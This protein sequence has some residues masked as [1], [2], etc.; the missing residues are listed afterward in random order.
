MP[1][2]KKRNQALQQAQS[3]ARQAARQKKAE[4]TKRTEATQSSRTT[5]TPAKRTETTQS[6]RT[7]KTP[8]KRTETTQSS[9]TTKT[10]A[11][12]KSRTSSGTSAIKTTTKEER[13][14][15]LPKGF[16]VLRTN[17]KVS[18]LGGREYTSNKIQPPVAFRATLDKYLTLIPPADATKIKYRL[19]YYNGTFG[20][21]KDINKIY[22]VYNTF[23]PTLKML[24]QKNFLLKTDD[25]GHLPAQN[26]F[27]SVDGKR[28]RTTTTT[29]TTITTTTSTTAHTND[30]K[31]KA[32]AFATMEDTI[33]NGHFGKKPEL[34]GGGSK[35]PNAVRSAGPEVFMSTSSA[36]D[37][38][39]RLTHRHAQTACKGVPRV[40][41]VKL[42][43]MGGNA[44]QEL[45]C[46][47]C[48]QLLGMI[49]GE[50]AAIHMFPVGHSKHGETMKRP[51][52][53]YR[54]LALH[55]L[56]GLGSRLEKKIAGV[57]SP[58]NATTFHTFRTVVHRHLLFHRNNMR[59]LAYEME[60]QLMIE[61]STILLP[62]ISDATWDKEKIGKHCATPF[63]SYRTGVALFCISNSKTS[64]QNGMNTN[65]FA[66]NDPETS[67]LFGEELEPWE[68]TSK[69]MES[70]TGEVGVQK[71]MDTG[72]KLCFIMDKDGSMTN[73]CS[74]GYLLQC[75][76]H[77]GTGVHLTNPQQLPRLNPFTSGI[78]STPAAVAND[79]QETFEQESV[80]GKNLSR[81]CKKSKVRVV[82]LFVFCFMYCFVSVLLLHVRVHVVF[83]CYVPVYIC[84]V[85]YC[86]CYNVCV[87]RGV[88]VCVLFHV[89]FC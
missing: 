14:R 68:G 89:L 32:V 37:E 51:F 44:I 2:G 80:R 39:A 61:E 25:T 64:N 11:K 29:T 26:A 15:I 35:N 45:R 82:L 30:R 69:Y 49:R 1:G 28:A 38:V 77:A 46:A 6:S 54:M 58:Y 57:G 71:L 42:R 7:T 19:R 87:Y 84:I 22:D 33:N 13:K 76:R 85:L 20:S 43:R 4:T 31:R 3:A 12:R 79:N 40:T 81:A 78:D 62:V 36:T 34:H 9:H 72:L 73:V 16:T 41:N 17:K 47:S 23:T 67:Q 53:P 8:A 60:V 52:G 50:S 59:Q 63:I 18:S 27:A 65:P 83:C 55:I 24:K 86:Q 10:P 21:E 74:L 66:E 5:K 88:V 70:V 75:Q 48:E 56:R